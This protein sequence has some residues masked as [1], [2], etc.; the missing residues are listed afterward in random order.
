MS[1]AHPP[2]PHADD[3]P[4]ATDEE[5]AA[6]EIRPMAAS[7]A[8]ALVEC[9]RIVY[10]D[11]Y[12]L[13]WAYDPDAIAARLRDGTML[14]VVAVRPDGAIAGH[15]GVDFSDP[16]D[17]V[18]ESA[19]AVV[20][21]YFRGHH[22]FEKLKL[23]AQQAAAQRGL[24][25][26]YSE[27]TA[28]HPYSQKGNLAL[29]A[30]E[31]GFLIGFVP[32]GIDYKGITPGA[33]NHRLTVAMFYLRTNK[34][35]RRTVHAPVFARAM[36]E[37]VY[38]NGDFDREFGSAAPPS[39]PDRA[40]VVHVVPRPDHRSAFLTA[41]V[42]GDDLVRVVRME[43][44]A[45]LAMDDIDCAYLDLPLADPATARAA[46]DLGSLGFTFGCVIP[47]LRPDGDVL[48]LQLL[49]D[50]DPHPGEISTASDF[51]QELLGEI[52]REMQA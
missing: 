49:N 27:A 13:T 11:S 6:L 31:T 28:A 8:P 21:P 16:G 4:V 1:E 35:P 33:E 52:L 34:E 30:H 24:L 14:S 15:V 29:G 3:H 51:G 7:D 39:E 46:E 26:L 41:A 37:E 20:D 18:G 9:F 23:Y 36:L 2:P 32:P 25:G 44:D 38:A 43:L 10:G 22:L 12:E 42:V 19:H 45:V 48:R 50:V 5:A 47:E 40:S 17:H